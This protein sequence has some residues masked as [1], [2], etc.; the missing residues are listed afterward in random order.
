MLKMPIHGPK[1]GVVWGI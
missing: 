1:F